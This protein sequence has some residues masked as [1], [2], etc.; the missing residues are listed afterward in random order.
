MPFMARYRGF[1]SQF[2]GSAPGW[3]FHAGTWWFDYDDWLTTDG[4][5]EAWA[6]ASY[7]GIY[8]DL[9]Y[10]ASLWSSGCT[11]CQHGLMV[12]GTP[13]PLGG[14]NRW[15][16]G[17]GFYINRS[18]HYAVFKYLA[19]TAV[20]LQNWTP[21]VAIE[22]GEAW[23]VLR[24]VAEG[25]SLRFYINGSL[26]WT[27][28]DPSFIGG[29]VGIT[30]Y[31]LSGSNLRLWADWARLT[32]I[33]PVRQ[34]DEVPPEQQALN[35]EAEERAGGGLDSDPPGEVLENEVIHVPPKP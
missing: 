28:V 19:G 12:R 6:S 8:G 34:A 11:S 22:Q 1:D 16:N 24:V 29:R 32:V 23:N 20:S 4:V 7:Q 2:S 21:S 3:Q 9:D 35:S 14:A 5:T 27:G 18:G 31:R 25:S 13:Y 15:S 26:V 10:Q 33:D 30:T 17:Y